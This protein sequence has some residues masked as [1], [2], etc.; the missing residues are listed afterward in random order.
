[1]DPPPAR[2]HYED[3]RAHSKAYKE[4]IKSQYLKFGLHKPSHYTW[5]QAE[6]MLW[7]FINEKPS[8]EPPPPVD[9]PSLLKQTSDFMQHHPPRGT[10]DQQQTQPQGNPT[11]GIGTTATATGRA[12]AHS[13]TTRATT[14][15]GARLKRSN[16]SRTSH[17]H[18]EHPKEPNTPT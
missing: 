2:V 13:A 8:T 4:W 11:A 3:G 12:P 17:R 1:M 14:T 16:S 7:R 10:P 18:K 5:Y 9:I 15:A 6:P